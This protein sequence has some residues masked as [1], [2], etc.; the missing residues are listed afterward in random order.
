MVGAKNGTCSGKLSTVLFVAFAINL[1]AASVGVDSCLDV[2]DDD[3]PDGGTGLLQ[4]I[5]QPSR[6]KGLFNSSREGFIAL[7]T[8]FLDN[9]W[10]N[11]RRRFDYC[12]TLKQNANNEAV[13]SVHL[14]TDLN[15]SGA[16]E[17]LAVCDLG[18][19]EHKISILPEYKNED[20]TYKLLF[21][22]ASNE[23][24][25]NALQVVLN[26][27]IV[28]GDWSRARELLGSLHSRKISLHLSWNGQLKDGVSRCAKE[29]EGGKIGHVV[30]SYDAVAFNHEVDAATL[31]TLGFRQNI[32]GAENK[33]VCNFQKA[34][35]RTLNVCSELKTYHVHAGSSTSNYVGERLNL[36]KCDDTYNSTNDW[37]APVALLK[38]I[39]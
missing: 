1:G 11:D 22:A 6:E 38:D 34:G 3:G 20:M 31:E 2:P 17:R 15:E 13:S 5:H 30:G 33:V 14:F 21:E 32:E 18:E 28:V 4:A 7:Y 35:W 10:D 23:A 25:A 12:H 39:I 24:S 29:Q 16:L 8:V 19:A 37:Y 27:D 36:G 9:A 26:A